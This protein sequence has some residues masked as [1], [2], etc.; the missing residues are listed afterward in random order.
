M[1][2]KLFASVLFL[3]A[4]LLLFGQTDTLGVKTK[5]F[6][7]YATA[8]VVY[9]NFSELN[10]TLSQIGYPEL[11]EFYG[12]PAYGVT[13][14]RNKRNDSYSHAAFSF[15]ASGPGSPFLVS[16][17]RYARL[18]GWE[19]QIGR[20]FDLVKS[21]NWLVY[22]YI[23]EGLGYGE[24]TLFDN[25]VQQ[26]FAA[27]AANLS[28][29][30]RKTWS[31]LYAYLGGGGGFEKKFRIGKFLFYMGATGGYRLNYSRFTEGYPLNSQAPIRLSGFEWN[32]RMRL[33][34]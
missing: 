1:I 14:N 6:G 4:P 27:S 3:A 16:T 21:P 23:I 30:N 33:V 5:K 24:L 15:L 7:F 11:R 29:P 9:P 18:R 12:G 28:V 25:I 22:P 8:S 31:S 13:F 17:P 34:F 10:S 20:V 32:L 26:S 19:I 2:L